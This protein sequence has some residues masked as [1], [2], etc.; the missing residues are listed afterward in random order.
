MYSM[1]VIIT[2][3]L[4][5]TARHTAISML[6]LRSAR[7][8]PELHRRI[9]VEPFDFTPCPPDS[10]N[11]HLVNREAGGRA[12]LSRHWPDLVRQACTEPSVVEVLDD[13]I[14]L[15]ALSE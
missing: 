8:Y 12:S 4:A 7:V 14:P 15:I 2:G 6:R 10:L 13:R 3:T 11:R 1:P 9:V 5:K